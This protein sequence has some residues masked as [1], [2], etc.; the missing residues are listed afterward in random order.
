MVEPGRHSADI[1]ATLLGDVVRDAR[2]SAGG[3]LTVVFGG[4]AELLV[5]ADADFESWAVAGADGLVVCLPG[6]EVAVWDDA[7]PT[8][9]LA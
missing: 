3:E 6:G 9:R 4:G 1:L 8:I 5:C 2:T 7:S